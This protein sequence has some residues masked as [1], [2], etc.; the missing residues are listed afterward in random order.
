MSNQ[1]NSLST[2]IIFAAGRG[3]RMRHLTENC[4]KPMLEVSGKSII[5]RLIDELPSQ[6]IKDVI[7]NLHYKGDI[8]AEH[9]SDIET[10]NIMLSHE[11]DL[12]ETGGGCA[13][14]L[15]LIG[16]QPFW[17]FNG[18]MLWHD[19]E[20]PMLQRM[21][22]MWDPAKMDILLLLHPKDKIAGFDGAGDYQCDENGALV[23]TSDEN[24]PYVFAGAR[25]AKPEIF[26]GVT[27]KRFSFLRLFDDAEKNGRLYGLVHDG[28]WYH[29]ST[30]E[31]LLATEKDVARAA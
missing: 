17:A 9:L 30:P 21:K 22:E 18:D 25:I 6:G 26:D 8:L 20:T 29:L 28:A 19:G 13:K 4:P 27:D 24:A 16:G 10:P 11:D 3:S 12:L 31:M 15:P 2:A 1:K 14:A 23:R 5:K 7:V